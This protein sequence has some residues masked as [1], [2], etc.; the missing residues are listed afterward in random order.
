[1]LFD[2]WTGSQTVWGSEQL[3]SRALQCMGMRKTP[4]PIK[5]APAASTK[6][7]GRAGFW[8]HSLHLRGS[9]SICLNL[10]V[11]HNLSRNLVMSLLRP[12]KPC[13][14]MHTC[15]EG[16]ATNGSISSFGE[17]I[18]P[19]AWDHILVLL[20]DRSCVRFRSPGPS[21]PPSSIYARSY[22]LD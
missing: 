1:M 18:D 21:P 5:E 17:V 20:F 12:A 19:F 2:L 3:D 16:G 6:A 4:S 13:D 10:I 14:N 22:D 8:S 11:S 7:P 15:H 9:Y